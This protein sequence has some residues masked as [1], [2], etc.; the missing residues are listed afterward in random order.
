MFSYFPSVSVVFSRY[1]TCWNTDISWLPSLH[2]RPWGP[3]LSSIIA[4]RNQRFIVTNRRCLFLCCWKSS[5]HYSHGTVQV[6]WQLNPEATYISAIDHFQSQSSI[7]LSSDI[8]CLIFSLSS[9]LSPLQPSIFFNLVHSVAMSRICST[10]LSLWRQILSLCFYTRPHVLERLS[11]WQMQAFFYAYA[12]TVMKH[13]IRM[14]SFSLI[15]IKVNVTLTN[16]CS[17]VEKCLCLLLDH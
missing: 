7:L 13:L 6:H 11:V 8:R 15:I 10:E 16:F 5:P 3:S 9:S 1:F 17:S 4:A 14:I 2:S 12:Y